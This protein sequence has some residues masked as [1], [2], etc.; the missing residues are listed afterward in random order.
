MDLKYF[1]SQ[2][3]LESFKVSFFKSYYTHSQTTSSV[4]S[5]VLR[6]KILAKVLTK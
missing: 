1:G 2:T 3:E 4:Q 5:Y 6:K